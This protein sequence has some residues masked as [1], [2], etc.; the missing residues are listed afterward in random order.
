VILAFSLAAGFAMFSFDPNPRTVVLCILGAATLVGLLVYPEL[1]LALYVVAGD[2]KG[3]D[4]IGS[5]LPWDL[6]L[7]LGAILLAGMVLNVVRRKRI[8]RMPSAYYLL[9][10]LVAMMTAS[11]SHTPVFEGGLEK[12]ARFLTVTGIVI[13]A[14]FLVLTTSRA[15]QR[16]LVGVGALVFGI[17]SLSLSGLHGSERL[18]SPSENTI[19][20][21]HVACIACAL[22]WIGVLP[23]YSMPKRMFVY[24]L[25]FVPLVALIG[26]GSRGPVIAFGTVVV[27]SLVLN[28]RRLFDLLCLGALGIVAMPFV[29]VPQPSLEYLGS[30]LSGRSLSTLMD[31]RAELLDYGWK[32]LQQHPMLG[33]GINGYRHY[34]PNSALYKWP[35][36]IFL[37]VACELGIPAGLIVCA[38]FASA[39][40]ESWRQLK[41]KLS[42]QYEFSQLAVALL[43]IGIVNAMNTGDINSDRSTWL[44]VS[45]V[46]VV[47]SVRLAP[48][49]RIGAVT[50]LTRPALA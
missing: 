33:T 2:I 11:L 9:V 21:G 23:R 10:A 41:D 22:I 26:S 36:N 31:F 13:V 30:M 40:R 32:L 25:F 16:F 43:A 49:E 50:G 46:F 45:L 7:V 20:L 4:H 24:L 17:C 19:G 44:F 3:D 5:I 12:L 18:V 39:L 8:V 35:H 1:A 34:S 38:L 15:M 48:A 28:W 47:R 42:P 14:P 27:A 37:E 6:T 29:K